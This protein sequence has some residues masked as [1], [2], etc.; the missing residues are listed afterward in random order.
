[1]LKKAFLIS[2]SVLLVFATVFAVFA[3]SLASSDGTEI[4]VSLKVTDRNSY[5]TGVAACLKDTF[6]KMLINDEF[7]QRFEVA[8]PQEYAGA[9]IDDFNTLH[10]VLTKNAELTTKNNY[11]AIMG[12][13]KD[14]IYEF[15]N[16][17]LSNL[18][19]A[20]RTL[21]GVLKEF[22]IESTGIDEIKNRVEISLLDNTKE[23]EITDFLKANLNGFDARCISFTNAFGITIS[24]A[25]NSTN[26]LAGSNFSTALGQGTLGFNAYQHAT[27]KSGV[28]TAAHLAPVAYNCINSMG[29]T[30][31]RTTES[32]RKF[33]G[34]MDAAFVVFDAGMQYSYKMHA[35]NSPDDCITHY[36]TYTN[37][38]VGTTMDKHGLTS[39]TNSGTVLETSIDFVYSGI[40]FTDQIKISNTQQLGDSG[41]PV[42]HTV[43]NGGTDFHVLAGIATFKDNNNYGY[44]SKVHNIMTQFGITPFYGV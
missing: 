42:F 8:Y 33:E 7:G 43:V 10:I 29:T 11:Q 16:F 21:R 44:V 36:Y 27:G 2:V 37:Y 35:Y 5:Y 23:K 32:N 1:M 6:P 20:Q 25:D 3:P 9:Y 31:G 18:Y 41:G 4:K 40:T 17:P 34:T 39:G 22:E 24:A 38:T 15:A 12:N 19:E 26:A 30:I 13:D 28:V 14:I